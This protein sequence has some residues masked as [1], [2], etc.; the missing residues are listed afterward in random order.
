M[1]LDAR[2]IYLRGSSVDANMGDFSL[3]HLV[4]A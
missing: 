1:A 3:F 2:T 4:F